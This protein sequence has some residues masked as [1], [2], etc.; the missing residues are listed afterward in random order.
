MWQLVIGF[1]IFA[2]YTCNNK[3]NELV[4]VVAIDADHPPKLKLVKL[5]IP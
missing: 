5:I 2:F 4:M 3:E 1:Q